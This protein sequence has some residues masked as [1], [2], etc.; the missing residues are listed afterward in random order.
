MALSKKA[1]SEIMQALAASDHLVNEE[2]LRELA[3]LSGNDPDQTV[4]VLEQMRE[5]FLKRK[6]D[7]GE[8]MPNIFP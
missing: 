2:T 4:L 1:W 5:S 3:E 6:H 8:P 7:G